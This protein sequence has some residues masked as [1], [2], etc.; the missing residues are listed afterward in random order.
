MLT[1]YVFQ[2]KKEFHVKSRIV[3]NFENLFNPTLTGDRWNLISTCAF[4][5]S[6]AISHTMWSLETLFPVHL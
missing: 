2:N 5:Q 4:I 1:E 3:L 6:V